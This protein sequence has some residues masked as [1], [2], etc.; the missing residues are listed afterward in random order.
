MIQAKNIYKSF[1]KKDILK[2]ITISV[3]IGHL[4]CILG[5]SG[6][7]KSTLLHILGTL[8]KPTKKKT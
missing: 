1:E 4:V 3:K 6:S 8:D 7:G 2:G 5:E